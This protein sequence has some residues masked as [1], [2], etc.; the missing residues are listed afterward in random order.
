MCH[1]RFYIAVENSVSVHVLYC[2]QQLINV[3]LD[4]LLR[5]VVGTALD[6]LVKIHFH[7]LEDQR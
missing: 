6:C 5:K 7:Q 1:L 3:V 4:T 2:L